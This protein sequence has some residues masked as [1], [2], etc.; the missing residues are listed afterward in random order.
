MIHVIAPSFLVFLI[1]NLLEFINI[2]EY[3]EI[4]DEIQENA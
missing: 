1:I 2:K 4:Q 3:G